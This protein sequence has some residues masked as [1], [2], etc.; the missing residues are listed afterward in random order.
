VESRTQMLRF[1]QNILENFPASIVGISREG[2]LVLSNSM[3]RKTFPFVAE[4]TAGV[5]VR[6]MFP[7]PISQAIEDCT[8]DG[9]PREVPTLEWD[10]VRMSVHVEP[11]AGDNGVTGVFL[12]LERRWTAG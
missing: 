10:R 3:A 5:D 9:R 7:D 1:S 4:L 2:W 11:L 6:F 8:D 12:I